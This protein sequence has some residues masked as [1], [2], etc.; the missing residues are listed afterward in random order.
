VAR[1]NGNEIHASDQHLREHHEGEYL[2]GG[3]RRS[4]ERGVPTNTSR[5]DVGGD[6]QG[7]ETISIALEFDP[8]S[9]VTLV[10]GCEY[11]SPEFQ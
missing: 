3:S 7:D 6:R 5:A 8:V 2:V 11:V 1:N 4:A 10:N 9:L